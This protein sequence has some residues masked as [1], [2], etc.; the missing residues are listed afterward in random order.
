MDTVTT[1]EYAYASSFGKNFLNHINEDPIYDN[2]I[3][4]VQNN[5]LEESFGD[6][7]ERMVNSNSAIGGSPIHIGDD[8][9]NFENNNRIDI[10][11][12]TSKQT[13]K[14][15]F[16]KKGNK[17]KKK[18]STAVNTDVISTLKESIEAIAEKKIVA[19]GK[20]LERRIK[21]SIEEV[22]NDV[23]SLPHIEMSSD[24]HFFCGDLFRDE[25]NNNLYKTLKN[26]DVKLKWLEYKYKSENKSDST[27]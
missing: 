22:M 27:G 11:K 17:G 25:S 2:V 9:I 1:G 24:I 10:Q 14:M 12:S 13:K 4:L 8:P 3:N 6:K 23:L 5:D 26:D 18:S 19:W 7:V 16:K 20:M 15:T 21:Y